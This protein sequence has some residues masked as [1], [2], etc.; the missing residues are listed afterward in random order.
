MELARIHC[1]VRV[2]SV[3]AHTN[4]FRND[5]KRYDGSSNSHCGV[6]H[7]RSNDKLDREDALDFV[8]SKPVISR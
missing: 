2:E 8:P 6:D 1:Y 3:N 7:P 4:V 5:L